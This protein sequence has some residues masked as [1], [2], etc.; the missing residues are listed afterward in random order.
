MQSAASA[1][2]VILTNEFA[3]TKGGIATFAEEIARAASQ[4]GRSVEVWAPQAQAARDDD[5]PFPI[6]RLALKG[7]QDL[8]CQLRLAQEMIRERRRLRRAI[9][10]LCEP[11]PILAMCYLQFFKCFRPGKLVVTF[12]GSEIQ[13]F[14]A[15]LGKRLA[16]N[17]LIKRADRISTP[18]EFTHGLLAR[19]FPTAKRKSF[20]TPGALRYNFG[21]IEARHQRSSQ[22]VNILT[23]GRIHPRKG[24]IFILNALSKLPSQ[25]RRHVSFWVVGS[26]KKRHGYETELR[27][28]AAKADFPV[29]FFGDVSNEQLDDL[30]A[31]ADLFSMTSVNF[32]KSVEGFG[33]VYL[34]AAAHGLPIVAHRVGGVAEAVSHG[35]NGI[36]VEPGNE[37]ELTAAFSRLIQD[38]ELRKSMGRNGK[39]WARRNTWLQSADLLFNRWDITIDPTL[40]EAEKAIELCSTR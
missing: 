9:V 13:A 34:E 38:S 23:V 28:L 25:L 11:G 31:R 21:E 29:T 4:L 22:Q 18:S 16:V 24:Q 35:E 37:A 36:L 6:R 19:L 32:R 10:Y 7:S 5:F 15:H 26:G 30:Y 8:A 39:S 3:P 17:A 2:I 33:L 1:P 20:L 27:S 12:H 40:N 14:A